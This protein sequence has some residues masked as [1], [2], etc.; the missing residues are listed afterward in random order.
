[1]EKQNI[2]KFSLAFSLVGIFAC[3]EA[4]FEYKII[5]ELRTK[6]KKHSAVWYVNAFKINQD[7]T[8]LILNSNNKRQLIKP[9]YIVR[10]L[11]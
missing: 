10:K 9:P 4:K 11:R 5:G 3:N 6:N 8:I 1:M 2:I 7:R